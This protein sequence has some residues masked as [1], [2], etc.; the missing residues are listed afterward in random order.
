MHLKIITHER[1]VFDEDVDEIYSKGVNGEFGILKG[2]IPY[3]TALD[4]GVTKVVQ[5][6]KTRYFT[7]MGGAFQFK[8]EEAL[9]LTECAECG[10]EIDEMRAREALD[11][12]KARLAEADAKTDA[13]R[14]EAAI[15]RAMARLKAKLNE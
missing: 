13:K 2:H 9:I 8:D 4:I 10:N 6:K 5:D 12:A 11:R 15:A 1:V 7:T 14:A 3:M